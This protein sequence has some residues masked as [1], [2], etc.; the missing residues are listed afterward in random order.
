MGM[1]H[2]GS[3]DKRTIISS[4]NGGWPKAD[5]KSD[6]AGHRRLDRSWL[7]ARVGR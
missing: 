7:G 6:K 4:Q 2:P 3:L 1:E 5:G